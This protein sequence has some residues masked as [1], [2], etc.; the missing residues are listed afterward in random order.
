VTDRAR[1]CHQPGAAAAHPW[2]RRCSRPGRSTPQPGISR[3]GQVGSRAF[4]RVVRSHPIGRLANANPRGQGHLSLRSR[5]R[6]R[7]GSGGRSAAD[8]TT[9][10]PAGPGN[11]TT[12]PGVGSHR[13]SAAGTRC[14]RGNA[15]AHWVDVDIKRLAIRDMRSG[16]EPDPLGGQQRMP[17]SG[18]RRVA[19]PSGRGARRTRFRT[20]AR[21]QGDCLC[22]QHPRA[23][24]GS[25]SNSP[26][27]YP[28]RWIRKM[29]AAIARANCW[30]S[31][32]RRSRFPIRF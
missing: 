32:V 2:P 31:P 15:R 24:S 20:S 19:W 4:A 11:L 27:C 12:T 10:R 30:R 26:S 6:C 17:C 9:Q 18:C 23:W 3:P 7:W 28:V 21:R 14:R 22:S 16:I 1:I 8:R 29:I 25:S 13:P 5:S